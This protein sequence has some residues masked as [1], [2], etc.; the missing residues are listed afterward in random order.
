MRSVQALA[1]IRLNPTS[2]ENF[3]AVACSL[4]DEKPEVRDKIYSAALEARSAALLIEHLR[5]LFSHQYDFE[6]VQADQLSNQTQLERQA[7]RRGLRRPLGPDEERHLENSSVNDQKARF[8]TYTT[9]QNLFRASKSLAA[10][11][12]KILY[13]TDTIDAQPAT[14]QVSSISFFTPFWVPNMFGTPVQM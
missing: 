12:A 3:L 4:A 1:Q 5:S 10:N 2:V 8:F 7:R 13:L 14:F 11:V 9:Q 6:L